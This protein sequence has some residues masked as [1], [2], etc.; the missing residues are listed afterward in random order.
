MIIRPTRKE[1][2]NQILNNGNERERAAITDPVMM[3]SLSR[4]RPPG[5]SA[6]RFDLWSPRLSL[7]EEKRLTPQ[8]ASID[9]PYDTRHNAVMKNI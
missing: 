5:A 9:P 3:H 2:S 8:R 7:S 4:I 1:I 6:S